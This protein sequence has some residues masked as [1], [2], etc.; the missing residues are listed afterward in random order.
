MHSLNTSI[1]R[2]R[3]A[4]QVK[5]RD[6]VP[7]RLRETHFTRD[8]LG[9]LKVEEWKKV[10]R[11]KRQSKNINSNAEVA[12]LILDEI[13]FNTK[14]ITRD[15]EEHDIM[16]RDDPQ[17]DLVILTVSAASSRASKDPK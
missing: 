9:R 11:G 16:K 5:T 12:I 14:K 13:T 1:R 4:E 17:E 8:G 15:K 2:Q 3:C 10:C 6:P 7:C